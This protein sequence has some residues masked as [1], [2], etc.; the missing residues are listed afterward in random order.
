MKRFL[1]TL[2]LMALAGCALE[3]AQLAQDAQSK[4]IGLTKESVLACMGIP[5]SKAQ[6]GVTEVWS[7]NSGNNHVEAVAFR[8]VAAA[9]SHYCVINVVM[10]GGKV[11]KVNYSGPTGGLITGGEQCAFAVQNC[12]R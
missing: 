5:A 10:S 4:M 1:S 12:A 2:C 3:R 7:Y 8:G 6:E 11:S 9:E